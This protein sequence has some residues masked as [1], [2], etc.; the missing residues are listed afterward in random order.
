MP[1]F[2]RW[3]CR[4]I[5]DD[6]TAGD[7]HSGFHNVYNENDP[8][9]VLGQDVN[10]CKKAFKTTLNYFKMHVKHEYH[11]NKFIRRMQKYDIENFKGKSFR[12]MSN[13]TSSQA[14]NNQS[15]EKMKRKE[16]GSIGNMATKARMEEKSDK[17][18]FAGNKD[19]ISAYVE[20]PR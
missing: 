16:G 2:K 10:A 19:K 11:N 12:L 4:Y 6:V 20:N 7:K 8:L 13:D 17:N 15:E 18:I 5:I 9:D 3:C 14:V 1:Y